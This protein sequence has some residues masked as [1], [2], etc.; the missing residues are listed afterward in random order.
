MNIWEINLIPVCYAST[1]TAGEPAEAAGR[2]CGKMA[3]RKHAWMA[4]RKSFIAFVIAG[5]GAFAAGTRS[6]E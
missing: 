3:A 5:F 4:R 2:G 1:A 6:V